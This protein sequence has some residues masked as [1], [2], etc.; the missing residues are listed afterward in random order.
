MT[1]RSET[2]AALPPIYVAA[3]AAAVRQQAAHFRSIR[4]E[5]VALVAAALLGALPFTGDASQRRAIAALVL[6]AML[7]AL[8]CRLWRRAHQL[9]DRWF[10]ARALAESVKA[11]A[12][13]FMMRA[14]PFAGSNALHVFGTRL[15]QLLR[16]SDE[17]FG[18]LSGYAITGT[19]QV[20][21]GMLEVRSCTVRERRD[22]YLRHRSHEQQ[23]WYARRAREHNR[24]GNIWGGTGFALEGAATTFA[25]V[26]LLGGLETSIVGVLATASAAAVA[27]LQA[28]DARRLAST[29]TL[30]AHDLMALA[31]TLGTPNREAELA[32]YVNE[33]ERTISREHTHWRAIRAVR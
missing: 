19:S 25:V 3:D 32:T 12:W 17:V 28:K 31:D 2:P 29:Y 33:V 9:E 13:R 24:T 11:D 14:P 1:T 6:L 27:W 8:V 26:A 21:D 10:Q 7:L 15:V 30:V 18:A 5:L 4:A 22:Y 23:A 20:T 16:A